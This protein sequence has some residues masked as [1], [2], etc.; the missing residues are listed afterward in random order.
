MAIEV[1]CS[2]DDCGKPARSRGLCNAHHLRLLRRGSTASARMNGR[3]AYAHILE[4]MYEDC[5]KWPFRR[6]KQG[7]GVLSLDGR[8]RL[9][10]NLVCELV[11]GKQPP[12]YE[13][14]HE[15]GKGSS[16]CFGAACLSWKTHAENMADAVRHGTMSRGEDRHT[17]RLTES[18]AIE[19][20][21]APISAETKELARRFGVDEETVRDVRKGRTWAWLTGSLP[22]NSLASKDGRKVTIIPEYEWHRIKARRQLGETYRAISEDYGV[23]QATIFKIVKNQS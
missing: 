8:D 4:H 14:A 7:Y 2:V 10:H 19:I 23:C 16:G 18:Q 5:P 21:R 20:Y 1:L 22:E 12:N 17:A 15:C 9:V 3:L 6:N 11:N 13:A